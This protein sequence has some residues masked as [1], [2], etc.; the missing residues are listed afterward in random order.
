[1]KNLVKR[2]IDF[3]TIFF[4]KSQMSTW[5]N[6][7]AGKC[8]ETLIDGEKYSVFQRYSTKFSILFC[9][10]RFG[11]TLVELLVVIAIIGVLIALLLP[12]VQAAREA[13][14]RMQCTNHLKQISL[15]V[16]NFHDVHQRFPAYFGD[17]LAKGI[18]RR[19]HFFVLLPFI[20][21]QAMYAACIVSNISPTSG[22]NGQAIRPISTLLC[23]SDGESTGWNVNGY[24]KGNIKTNYVGSLADLP[25]FITDGGYM[26]FHIRSWL[27]SAVRPRNFSNITDGT[28]NTV[29][30]SEHLISDVLNTTARGGNYRR[31]VAKVT[32]GAGYW[33]SP[34]NCLRLKGP[35]GEYLDPNQVIYDGEHAPGMR[36]FD[37]MLPITAFHTL[38]PP[39]SPSCSHI[40]NFND[41]TISAT[42]AH[43]GGVNVSFLDCSVTFINETIHVAN[44]STASDTVAN[45]VARDYD[46]NSGLNA[47]PV[48]Y[49]LWSELGSING[50]ET[51][52]KP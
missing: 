46:R 32:D 44:L 31:R 3:L 41:G 33:N 40:N 49:G 23:P 28:S 34:Q 14:R 26:A 22:D 19:N 37:N 42:S 24:G 10:L 25:S 20:E 16:H 2:F 35:G 39:N 43:S 5:A 36:A 7:G 9:S 13:A 29:M 30:H 15:S 6:R 50:S 38:L 12:A 21:Q 17:P 1:M 4:E 51:A 18:N 8:R 48:S 47:P 52:A 45:V 27:E 11:F